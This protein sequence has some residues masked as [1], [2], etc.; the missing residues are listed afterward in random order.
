MGII[1][2]KKDYDPFKKFIGL[3]SFFS[4]TFLWIMNLLYI[5]SHVILFLTFIFT[6][7]FLASLIEQEII[8]YKVFKINSNPKVKKY[9]L[10]LSSLS[11]IILIIWLGIYFKKIVAIAYFEKGIK[12]LNYNNSYEKGLLNFK[13]ALSWDISD[14]YYQALS[15]TDILK[16]RSVIGD[17]Q[18]QISNSPD[19]SVNPETAKSITSLIGE[20][21]EYTKKAIALD[22]LNYYNYIA[23]A[24]VSDIASSLRIPGAYEGVKNSYGNAISLNPSNP[25]LYLNLARFETS[26]NK[27]KQAE[28]DIGMALR[29]K[30]NYIEAIFLLSQIQVANGQIKDAI[31]SAKVATDINPSDPI[32]FFQLG[33]LYYNDKNYT[34]S[35]NAFSKAISLNS[36]YANARYFLGLSLIRLGRNA[37]AIEQFVELE[38]TNPDN[39]EIAFI[40]ANIKSGKSPFADAKPPIDSKP[41][42]RSNLP[43][44][45]KNID[46]SINN[47][48]K[49]K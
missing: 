32:L 1:L 43:V 18:A 19:K 2:F 10:S 44:K 5:P 7:I 20:A 23:Q 33:F 28:E 31:I 27:L 25:S 34:E 17:V 41:E 8:S 6:G 15:E 29:I 35:T 26:Q 14:I 47:K 40:L 16:V 49:T 9:I 30:P 37:E 21:L 38:K 11:L 45:E 24:R 22:P 12:E 36:Q 48:I 13:K 42:K 4:A 3:S 39:K 46:K